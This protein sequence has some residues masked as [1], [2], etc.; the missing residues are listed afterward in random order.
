MTDHPG[1][2]K[3]LGVIAKET[4]Y[5]FSKMEQI[6]CGILERHQSRKTITLQ[7]TRIK[8]KSL[9][10]S[11]QISFRKYMRAQG[12]LCGK[13]HLPQR[14][15]NR[16]DQEEEQNDVDSAANLAMDSFTAAPRGRGTA[17]RQRFR[18]GAL[19]SRG[20]RGRGIAPQT[21]QC[22][23]CGGV[24]NK[25]YL[26]IHQRQY[27][28]GNDMRSTNNHDEQTASD[29]RR[30]C[31]GC[32]GFYSRQYLRI[33]KL[34]HC[35]GNL[36]NSDEDNQNESFDNEEN[37]NS[38]ISINS[39]GEGLNMEDVMAEVDDVEQ[40]INNHRRSGSH[41]NF[42]FVDSNDV[43][44]SSTLII[45]PTYQRKRF[46][47]DI[48]DGDDTIATSVSSRQRLSIEDNV[49]GPSSGMRAL[50]PPPPHVN[51][52]DSEGTLIDQF[53]NPVNIDEVTFEVDGRNTLSASELERLV[54]DNEHYGV[55]TIH[56]E[57]P[58]NYSED[59]YGNSSD[60]HICG[61]KT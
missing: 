19:R 30:R 59:L 3:F 49:A 22:P 4:T 29:S 13:V 34:H 33:H 28:Q 24:Y 41:I 26:R 31:E 52:Y 11:N 20:G 2:Y 18:G 43:P 36:H 47:S 16:N 55:H 37:N 15:R 58:E 6:E 1:I 10:L 50:T 38:D 46:L 32:D 23:N 27:C 25:T 17:L 9:L 53:G 12:A 61:K 54:E 35:Q 56:T 40:T 14:Q 45:P 48:Y 8:L 42:D 7:K 21:R 39:D 5:S 51:M 44:S 57:N 60:C